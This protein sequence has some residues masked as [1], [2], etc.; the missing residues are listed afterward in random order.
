MMIIYTRP[1]I[2]EPFLS[3]RR[4][5]IGRYRRMPFPGLNDNLLTRFLSVVALLLLGLYYRQA[6]KDVQQQYVEKAR[7]VV[8]TTESTR[9]EMAAKWQ[10]GV[11]TAEQLRQWADAQR[12]DLILSAVPVVSAWRAAQAKAEEGGY[13]FRVPKFELRNPKNQTDAREAEVLEKLEKEQLA[14]YYLVDAEQN[15]IRYFRPIKLTQECMLCHGDPSTS[16]QLWGN[17]Q[18]LDPTGTKMENWKV[19]EMHG[20]FEVIQSL[21]K[22]DAQIASAMTYGGIIVGVLI[23]TGAVLFYWMITRNVVQP[24][25]HIVYEL[26]DGADQVNDAAAQV[27]QAAQHLA[28]GATSQAASLQETSSALEELSAMTQTNVGNASNADQYATKAH[29]AAGHSDQTIN[30]LNQAMSG[31]NESAGHIRKIIKVIEEIAFQTNLLALNAAVEAARAGE[32]GKGFAVV[33][34]EVRSL[35]QRSAQAAKETTTLIEDSVDRANTGTIVT[36]E[37][38]NSLT[39]IATDISKVSE[40]MKSVSHASHEQAEGLNHINIAMAQMD[41]IT[42]QNAASAEQSAAAS[43]QL[44]AQAGCVKNTVRDLVRLVQ[45]HE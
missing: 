9:E 8:L 27:S 12:V 2:A 15:A 39:G 34:D 4:E 28:E 5:E 23:L 41:K 14:E 3:S 13:E 21:D 31:I 29:Q 17:D 18:G 30:E 33:A 32:H 11:H 35:A 43:E 24:I 42:Q 1:P 19:G 7:S 36:R 45:G 25:N 16:Q 40:L 37:V 44:S 6:R 10:N 38:A 22:A 20:A 26:N